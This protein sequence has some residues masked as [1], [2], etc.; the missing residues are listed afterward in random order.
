MNFFFLKTYSIFNYCSLSMSNTIQALPPLPSLQVKTMN[1]SH[2][3]LEKPMQLPVSSRLDKCL[4]IQH[5]KD[6]RSTFTRHSDNFFLKT[7]L[8]SKSWSSELFR[9]VKKFYSLRFWRGNK[10]QVRRKL[11]FYQIGSLKFN[12]FWMDFYED[13]L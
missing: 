1:H 12:S 9:E 3:F 13:Y 4:A 5:D 6:F 7:S 2:T 11:L 8:V 10:I